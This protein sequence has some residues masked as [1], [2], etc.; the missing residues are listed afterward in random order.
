METVHATSAI[1]SRGPAAARQTTYSSR[2]L[3]VTQYN[4]Q[5]WQSTSTPVPET[6]TL[7]IYLTKVW[8]KGRSQLPPSQ[9]S[10]I[11][12][13][14][15]IMYMLILTVPHA[16]SGNVHTSK[17]KSFCCLASSDRIKSN[18]DML[19]RKTARY[20]ATDIIARERTR[21]CIARVYG[22]VQHRVRS[23]EAIVYLAQRVSG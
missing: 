12:V 14:I 5:E 1:C 6:K 16:P 20:D 18:A 13:C 21:D 4:C 19:H 15:F 10:F 11:Q 22:N 17:R 3:N 9:A 23:L 7:R 2:H 8:N